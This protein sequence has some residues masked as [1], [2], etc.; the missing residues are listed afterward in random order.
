MVI[1]YK[2]LAI[3]EAGIIAF[4]LVLLAGK[5][6]L[7]ALL[8]VGAVVGILIIAV[9][10]IIGVMYFVTAKKPEQLLGA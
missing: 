7:S 5:M 8:L 6:P 10:V 2:K 4:L 9:F 3:G 1:M